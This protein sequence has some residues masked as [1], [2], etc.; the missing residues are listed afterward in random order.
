M[1]LESAHITNFRLLED[2]SLKFSTDVAQP[3]TVFRAENGSGKT[4]VLYALRWA[5][6]GEKGIPPRMRLTSTAQALG[7]PTQV[8]VRVEFTTTDPFSGAEGH[9]RLIRTCDETPGEG[10]SLSRSESRLRLLLRTDS[11]EKDIDE[12]KE[13]LISAILPM[14]LADVFFTNGDDVQR[15]ITSGQHGGKERQDAVHQAIRKLLGLEDVET[16]LGNFNYVARRLRKELTSAGGDELRQLEV[17]LEKIEDQL[18]EQLERH[19]QIRGRKEFVD[20]LIRQDERELD[21]IRGIGDL[22][23]IQERIR[24]L[25]QDLSDLQQ[26]ETEIRRGMRDFLRSENLSNLSIG[27]HLEKGMAA[28]EELVS[29]KV[30]PGHSLEVLV[31][32]L[33]LGVCVCGADLSADKHKHAHVVSLIQEQ[34]TVA[35]QVQRLTELWHEARYSNKHASTEEDSDSQTTQA[36]SLNLKFTECR[37]RQTRKRADLIAEQ[38][39]RGQIDH[40]RVQSLTQRLLS[41]RAGR[42]D[43]DRDDGE[44]SGRIQELEEKQKATKERFRIAENRVSLNRRLKRQSSLAD[45]LVALAGGTLGRIKANYVHRVSERMNEL[46]MEIV[47]ADPSALTTVFT[48]VSIDPTSYDIVIHS[49]EGKTLDADTE[50]NG[51]SQR[52]LTLSFIWALMEVAQRESPRIID[53]PL[54]MTSGAV[55]HRMV[56]LLTTPTSPSGLPYQAI[57]FMTRSEIRDIEELISARAGIITTLSC[58]KDYPVDLLNDWSGGKPFVRVCSCDHTE[59]CSTC[60]RRSDAGRFKNRELSN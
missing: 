25:E 54:G 37:D 22:E 34:Q 52:A 56:D 36:A 16:V 13:G 29:R 38:E 26:Q 28:L 14:N 40:E 55:K 7:H 49:L 17:E 23:A 50:L 60:A 51:A 21:A 9:Y 35:P 12:G 44:L 1:R 33:A 8:Q 53:T 45:D 41:N 2:V 39:K 43:L 30:I 48:G 24:S 15:F 5:L 59:V 58:S 47:G 20:E 3:L 46:F 6:Y 11:G 10:D 42:S 27:S 18:F 57:L 4:S 19:S 31:D 32:R